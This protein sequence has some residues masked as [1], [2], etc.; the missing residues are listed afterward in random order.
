MTLL[1]SNMKS[2]ITSSLMI[3]SS[4]IIWVSSSIGAFLCDYLWILKC[5]T[6]IFLNDKLLFNYTLDSSSKLI[7]VFYP[8]ASIIL[9]YGLNLSYKIF[10]EQSDKNFLKLTFGKYVSPKIIDIMFNEKKIPQLGG[11]SGIRTA[12]FSDIQSFSTISEKLS[13]TKLVALLNEFL[14]SQTNII[15]ELKGT[16][17]KYEGDSIVAF[18]GAPIYFE[19]HAKASQL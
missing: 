9:T 1:I 17:D 12:F 2:S 14:S 19:E 11:E 13:S 6:N 5:I 7:P 10:K 18:F 8:V 4:V 3:F 15:L 16:L